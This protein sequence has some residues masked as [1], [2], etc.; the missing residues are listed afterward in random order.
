M[1]NVR[2]VFVGSV[3]RA[4]SARRNAVASSGARQ[5]CSSSCG[6]P[7]VRSA[8]RSEV[9]PGQRFE[10]GNGASLEID[11]RLVDRPYPLPATGSRRGLGQSPASGAAP[12]GNC[13]DG[14]A[15][16]VDHGSRNLGHAVLLVRGG[17]ATLA[18]SS[19]SVEHSHLAWQ[20][21]TTSPQANDFMVAFSAVALQRQ[22]GRSS[23]IGVLRSRL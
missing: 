17:T 13:Q 5:P 6:E 18:N 11:D 8:A 22:D 20:P 14:A 21:G 2:N 1:F 23:L 15:D 4:E 7:R 12:S 10:A 19:S 16:L 3:A 9:E